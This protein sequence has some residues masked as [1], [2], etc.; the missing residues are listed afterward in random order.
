[1]KILPGGGTSGEGSGSD[2]IVLPQAIYGNVYDSY[3]NSLDKCKII[4]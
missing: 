4:R 2:N 3:G 1:M